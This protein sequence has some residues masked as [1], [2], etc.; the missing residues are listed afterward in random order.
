MNRV[1]LLADKSVSNLGGKR[2]GGRGRLMSAHVYLP[3]WFVPELLQK[4]V[5]LALSSQAIHEAFA[6]WLRV[7]CVMELAVD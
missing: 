5:L 6:N 7:V 3:S 1:L 4:G 2:D